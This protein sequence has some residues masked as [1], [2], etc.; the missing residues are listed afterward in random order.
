MDLLLIESIRGYRPYR[1]ASYFSFMEG[2][3][4][5]SITIT[6]PQRGL[7]GLQT[8]MEETTRG[9]VARRLFCWEGFAENSKT[10]RTHIGD[11]N[12]IYT[13]KNCG[14][15]TQASRAF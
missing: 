12:F 10:K 5:A 6:A 9:N 15:R 13:L 11:R 1:I 2:M 3:N 8:S 4:S 14:Q 7:D